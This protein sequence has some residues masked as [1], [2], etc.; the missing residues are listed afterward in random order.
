MITTEVFA[1][2]LGV[3]RLPGATTAD[4]LR[5]AVDFANGTLP[6]TLGATLIVHP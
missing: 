2:A 5:Q 3:V 4:F 6:G 1:S